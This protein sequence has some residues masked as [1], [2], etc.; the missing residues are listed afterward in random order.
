MRRRWL[1]AEEYSR[2][3][4]LRGQGLTYQQ[5]ASRFGI[6]LPTIETIARGRSKP[7]VYAKLKPSDTRSAT[8]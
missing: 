7:H 1:T 5:I 8:R 2:I 6:P 3:K 4:A